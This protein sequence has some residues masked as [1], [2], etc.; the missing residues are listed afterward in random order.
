MTQIQEIITHRGLKIHKSI[1]GMCMSEGKFLR[2]LHVT[3]KIIEGIFS[4][5]LSQAFTNRLKLKK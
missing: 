3:D 4:S 2:E 1:W 5:Y